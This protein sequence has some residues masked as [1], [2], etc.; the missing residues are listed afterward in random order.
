[1]DQQGPVR[2]QNNNGGPPAIWLSQVG[3]HLGYILAQLFNLTKLPSLPTWYP[4]LFWLK[5]Y[6]ALDQR[7]AHALFNQS[8]S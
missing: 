8:E 5:Y 1:M 4:G 6:K 3:G 2:S 7:K